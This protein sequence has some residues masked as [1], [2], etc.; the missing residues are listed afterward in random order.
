MTTIA[1]Q[2]KKIA[3]LRAR[4]AKI[5]DNR[6]GR[7]G[8]ALRN[9]LKWLQEEIDIESSILFRMKDRLEHGEL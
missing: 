7:K 1:E 4:I 2:E 6:W 5:E 3:K 8:T 9:R